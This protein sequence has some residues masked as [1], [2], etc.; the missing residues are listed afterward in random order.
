MKPNPVIMRQLKRLEKQERRF[1]NRRESYLKMKTSPLVENIQDKVPDKLL[2]TLEKA[3]Y[4]GFQ[5]VF[6]KGHGYIERTYDRSKLQLNHEL[7]NHQWE[8]K[9]KRKYLRRIDKRVGRSRTLNSGISVLE[10]GILGILGIGLPDIP[11]LISVMMRTI[12]ETSVSY[13]FHYDTQEERYYILLLIC[14]ALTKGESQREFNNK[15]DQVGIDLNYNLPIEFDIR[16]QMGITA[17]ILSDAMVTAKFIQGIPI[18]GAVGSIANYG[19]IKKVGQY[20]GLKYKKRY[21]LKKYKSR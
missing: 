4:K 3:F 19:I 5:L 2:V 13:G 7:N 20:A 11:L 17:G 12:Y 1:L 21:L 6:E 14:G 9:G 18:I 10:G 8:Q 16:E 15:V